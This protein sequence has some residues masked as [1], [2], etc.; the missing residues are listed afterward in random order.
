MVPLAV[1]AAFSACDAGGNVQLETIE[2]R[3]SYAVGVNVGQSM[4]SDGVD[5]DY[6]ALQAGLR[7]VVSGGEVKMTHEELQLAFQ[8]FSTMARAQAQ[9]RA[10]EVAA[11]NL[12]EGAAFLAENGARDGVNTTESGL[13]WE[14]VTE[15]TGARP[16][17][18]DRVAVNYVGTLI[19]G[20]EFDSSRD[21]EQPA[22]FGVNQV[23]PGWAE[24]LQLM[25][26]G[27]IYKVYVPGHLGY[28]M[29]GSGPLIGPNA[30]LVFE[31]TL[32]GIQ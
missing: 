11:T 26:E 27:S 28:G 7:D 24:A 19:D 25:T 21:P 22:V 4:V 16:T 17:A 30:T 8:E 23:I 6:D 18:Q 20:T 29:Q 13:Q 1:L 9:E 10:A 32:L 15:G 12:T 2:Q 3:G 31:V 14:V 5:F